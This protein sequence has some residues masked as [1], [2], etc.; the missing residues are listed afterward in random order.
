MLLGAGTLSFSMKITGSGS[1]EIA[2][3]GE[4]YAGKFVGTSLSVGGPSAM[5]IWTY[6]EDRAPE[7]SVLSTALGE[8]WK[9]VSIERAGENLKVRIDGKVIHEAETRTRLMPAIHFL[10]ESAELRIKDLRVSV[11]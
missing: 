8:G 11:K 1:A 4:R 3:D 7:S 5:N 10:G 6:R 9:V 2:I